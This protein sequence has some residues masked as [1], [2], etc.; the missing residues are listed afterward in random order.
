MISV[1]SVRDK[2]TR[3]TEIII[4][5]LISVRKTTVVCYYVILSL[6]HYSVCYSVF[7]L[8]YSWSLAVL[9]EHRSTNMFLYVNFLVFIPFFLSISSFS[10]IF[11]ATFATDF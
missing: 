9:V 6:N 10:N 1:I 8:H 11:F 5:I 7:N 2:K 4:I 3:R